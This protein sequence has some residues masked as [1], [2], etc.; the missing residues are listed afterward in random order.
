[1][2]NIPISQLPSLTA[3]TLN[4]TMVLVQGGVT[5]QISVEDFFF[6]PSYDAGQVS[7][8]TT[9]DLS[10]YRY[11]IFE[12]TGN[13]QVVLNNAESGAEYLFWVYANGSFSVTSMSVPGFDLYTVGGTL[14]NPANNA[15][16]LYKGNVIGTNFILTEIGNFSQVP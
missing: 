10:N 3:R 13:V 14:P 8:S 6:E 5:S 15:W 1:M 11:F 9:V 7:G 4:D 16:N 2:A 12:L